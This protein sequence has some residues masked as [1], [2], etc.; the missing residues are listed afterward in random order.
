MEDDE[1]TP[2]SGATVTAVHDA[3]KTDTTAGD[4]S[5]S[6]TGFDKTGATYKFSVSKT[7]YVDRVVT[8]GDIEAGDIILEALGAGGTI[9]GTVTLGD[10]PAPFASGTVSIK[11]KAG[12]QYLQDSLGNVITAYA[13][14][15]DGTYTFTV[16]ADYAADGPFTVEFR[17]MGYI[18]GE[19]SGGA[20]EGILTGVA[21]NA[22]NADITLNPVTIISVTGTAQDVEPD[23]T[24]DQVLVKITA[25]AGLTPEE[26]DGTTT[27]IQVLDSSGN[28]LVGSLDVFASEGAKTWSFTH[29]AYENFSITVYADVSEDRD[30]DA[31]YKVTKTWSYVKSA[32]EPDETVVANPYTSGG[33][34]SS[35]S[36]DTN[37]TL[38][39]GGLLGEVQDVYTIAIVEADASDADATQITGSEIVEVV[40]MNQSGEEVD[41]SEIER[42]EITIKFD[43]TIVTPGTLEAGTYVIYQA[44]SMADLVAGSSSAVPASQIIQPIDYVNGYVTFWVNHLSAFGIGG[45][46]SGVPVVGSSS[47]SGCFIETIENDTAKLLIPVL[48]LLFALLSGG[49]MALKKR[50]H[51]NER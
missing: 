23:G 22:T 45:S 4:G 35:T 1:V 36:G 21:L 37:V 17:K 40:M 50:G 28:D 13:D 16:P 48:L 18:F 49:V 10:D 8:V 14:A 3:S 43:P 29:T 12:G 33:T 42:I 47:S 46:L 6:I 34:A 24:D 26:F 20:T 30:V 11:V 5:F 9:A 32:T 2:I 31:G 41:N 39:P 19:F 51:H 25:Q 38:P 27:E 44:S 15:S 7:G